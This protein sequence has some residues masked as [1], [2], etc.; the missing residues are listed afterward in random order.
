M[1]ILFGDLSHFDFSLE[2][3]QFAN[4][5]CQSHHNSLFIIL[6]RL[7]LLIELAHW[8]HVSIIG[9]LFKLLVVRLSFSA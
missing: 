5:W 8:Y 2:V 7:I 6:L 1:K 3:N 9:L 4:I